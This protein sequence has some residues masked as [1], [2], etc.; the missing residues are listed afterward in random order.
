MRRQA[1]RRVP[2][3]EGLWEIPWNRSTASDPSACRQDGEHNKFSEIT[4]F[5]VFL[6]CNSCVLWVTPDWEKG[7]VI[8]QF[9][10]DLLSTQTVFQGMNDQRKTRAGTCRKYLKKQEPMAPSAAKQTGISA[11]FLGHTF[12]PCRL[13][14][15]QAKGNYGRNTTAHLHMETRW[16][17]ANKAGILLDMACMCLCGRFFL[18]C[19]CFV[20]FSPKSPNYCWTPE[21]FLILEDGLEW[22]F[23]IRKWPWRKL[24]LTLSA[25]LQ[26]SFETA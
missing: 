21:D 19:F 22:G 23:G 14:P 9:K 15:E 7:M 18:L 11:S 6:F 2:V 12:S 25:P 13:Y 10:K 1:G 26:A 20:L 24:L 4:Y 17:T 16:A 5:H 3:F 8:S